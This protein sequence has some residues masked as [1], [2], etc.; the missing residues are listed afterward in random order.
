MVLRVAAPP[1]GRRT[2]PGEAPLSAG[3]GPSRARRIARLVVRRYLAF[4]IAAGL[5]ALVLSDVALLGEIA[6]FLS[7]GP[8]STLTALT[9]ISASALLLA[10]WAWPVVSQLWAPTV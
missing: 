2:S 7:W 8:S 4:E 10:H 1:P 3:R 6:R 5:V 9:S